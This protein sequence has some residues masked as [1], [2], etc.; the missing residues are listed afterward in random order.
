MAD[1]VTIA[2]IGKS[3]RNGVTALEGVDLGV[4]EGE[5]LSVLGPSGCGQSTLRAAVPGPARLA[6]GRNGRPDR[7]R[8]PGADADALGQGL[9]QCL[10]AFA[11]RRRAAG[12]PPAA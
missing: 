3:F 8:L 7:L 11:A 2:G 6:R 10:S 1:L 12:A 5:F 9:G 4:A